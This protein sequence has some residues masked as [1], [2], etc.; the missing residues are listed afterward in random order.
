MATDCSNLAPAVY[1][2]DRFYLVPRITA[3]GYLERILEICMEEHIDGVFSLIDPELSLLA[4]ERAL[5]I[6]KFINRP[7]PFAKQFPLQYYHL[8]KAFHPLRNALQTGCRQPVEKERA[9]REEERGRGVVKDSIRDM[10][11]RYFATPL[12]LAARQGAA[13]AGPV[14]APA[15][16]RIRTGGG[17]DAP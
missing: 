15:S 16:P 11:E 1:D 3:P 17:A 14:P 12:E 9:A 2:A 6:N 10:E 7:V 13:C 4:K 5:N 8:E